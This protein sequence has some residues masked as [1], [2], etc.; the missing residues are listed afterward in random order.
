MEPG[1]L[2]LAAAAASGT[3][4]C[5]G[6]LT[7]SG[8]LDWGAT[9]IEFS[10][11]Y[12][13]GAVSPLRSNV[14]LLNAPLR[15]ELDEAVLKGTET[16]G[17]MPTPEGHVVQITRF[18]VSRQ[19]GKFT[20]QAMVTREASGLAVGTGAWEGACTPGKDLERKF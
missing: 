11:A 17:R 19:T 1:I 20:L 4:F 7:Q 9:G 2:I 6:A 10:L 3:L 15:I 8:G 5:S 16:P 18:E 12:G 13:P 14:E